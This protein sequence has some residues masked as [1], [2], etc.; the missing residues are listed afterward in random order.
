VEPVVFSLAIPVGFSLAIPVVRHA[1][2][3]QSSQIRRDAYSAHPYEGGQRGSSPIGTGRLGARNPFHGT[4]DG[5][6]RVGAVSVQTCICKPARL[7]H[8]RSDRPD[9]GI[10]PHGWWVVQRP[11]SFT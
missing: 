9:M 4:E 3:V 11:P 1:A 2:S 7:R 8:G 10:A 6:V 5:V